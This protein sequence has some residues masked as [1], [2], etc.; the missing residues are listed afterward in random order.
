MGTGPMRSGSV[1]SRTRGEIGGGLVRR[2]SEDAHRRSAIITS[3]TAMMSGEKFDGMG[4]VGS[5]PRTGT[6][7][8]RGSFDGRMSMGCR[9]R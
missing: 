2:G 5:R 4:V 1:A 7:V 6:M 8:R 9:R 3:S